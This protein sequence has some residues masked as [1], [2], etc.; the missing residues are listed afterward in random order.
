MKIIYN[1]TDGSIFNAVLER[2]I[3]TFSHSIN[4]ATQELTI[5][6]IPENQLV[7]TDLYKKVGKIDSQGLGKYYI[8]NGE[9][10]E[11]DGWQEFI[12]V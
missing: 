10:F 4:V 2:D 8:Q 12:N 11:R 7:I 1:P 9:L 6:E 3:L 5:D